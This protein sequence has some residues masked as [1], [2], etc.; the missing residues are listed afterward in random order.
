MTDQELLRKL[1]SDDDSDLLK[2]LRQKLDAELAKPVTEQDFDYIDDLAKTIDTITGADQET[3]E[4]AD[5]GIQT[6]KA[7]LHNQSRKSRIKHLRWWIPAACLILIVG[8]N[9]WTYTAFG[10]NAFSAA[11]QIL[12]GGI[13]VDLNSRDSADVYSGNPYADDV[14]YTGGL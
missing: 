1:Q 2:E 14:L 11:Y 9:I 10:M 8:T 6:I 7:G 5:R 3:A 4:I 12:N 13:N